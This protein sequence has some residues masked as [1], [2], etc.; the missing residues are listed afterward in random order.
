MSTSLEGADF[1]VATAERKLKESGS[2]TV[3]FPIYMLQ[4]VLELLSGN[5]AGAIERFT[6]MRKFESGALGMPFVPHSCMFE[7]LAALDY[8]LLHS[9]DRDAL[10]R[11]ARKL[12]R[13]G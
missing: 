7:S 12:L 13:R 8:A 5:Y 11:R 9:A 4:G 1:D 6:E 2:F 3:L 10:I